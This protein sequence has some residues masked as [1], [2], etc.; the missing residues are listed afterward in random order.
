MVSMNCI[1]RIGYSTSA[2]AVVV[3]VLVLATPAMTQEG[4]A[5]PSPAKSNGTRPSAVYQPAQQLQKGSGFRS[6]P[7]TNA[8]GKNP[9]LVQASST[10][11]GNVTSAVSVPFPPTAWQPIPARREW[12]A[13]GPSDPSIQSY[14]DTPVLPP[15]GVLC[16]PG[17][18]GTFPAQQASPAYSRQPF[19]D[20]GSVRITALQQALHF[21]R[22]AGSKELAQQVEAELK[23]E[24]L[25]WMKAE[26]K[27]RQQEVQ[28]LEQSVKQLEKAI[29]GS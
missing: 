17:Y 12:L 23:T 11:L 27:R 15:S 2:L 10:N 13:D 28:V 21:L 26:L 25:K 6:T 4:P 1:S 19:G 14:S 22:T 3:A 16:P 8:N 18:L 5:L 7:R 20:P 24:R 9:G 29:G